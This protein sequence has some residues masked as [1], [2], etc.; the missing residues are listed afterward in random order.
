MNTLRKFFKA[1]K[2]HPENKELTVIPRSEILAFHLLNNPL[3][4]VS[5][6]TKYRKLF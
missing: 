3:Q 1:K 4:K 2:V 5:E 6:V